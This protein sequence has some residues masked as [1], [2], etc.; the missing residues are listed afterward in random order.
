MQNRRPP[1]P[2][3]PIEEQFWQA[4]QRRVPDIPLE[5]QY[6]AC[7]GAYR[8]DFAH[9]PSR[10]AIELDGY[11]HH[12]SHARFTQD[13]RR[14]RDLVREGWRVLVF[15]GT[16][17]FHHADRCVDEA[18]ATIDLLAGVTG[19]PP[20]APLPPPAGHSPSPA[21]PAPV[22]GRRNRV[23]IAV[24]ALVIM[25][26]LGFTLVVGQRET[27]ASG[28]A[29]TVAARP[30]ARSWAPVPSPTLAFEPPRPAVAPPVEPS[31]IPLRAAVVDSPEL[32]V[33]DQPGLD[34]P[35]IDKIKQGTPVE[36]LSERV[37]DQTLWAQIRFSQAGAASIGWVNAGYLR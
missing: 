19:A 32:N 12:S 14:H 36:V 9:P 35:V 15:S 20:T 11:T 26:G 22:S 25:L 24:L 4:W 16:E 18:R 1:R 28:S 23:F 8:L 7:A 2:E 17:V 13:R 10:I 6:P 21:I 29:T 5:L 33:R 31:A 30:T 27:P 34:G 3:S 37:V